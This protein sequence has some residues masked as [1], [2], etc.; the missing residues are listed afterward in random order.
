MI[1]VTVTPSVEE[2]AS[3]Y[4][5]L[6]DFAFDATMG[7]GDILNIEVASDEWQELYTKILDEYDTASK[8]ML[9]YLHFG[10]LSVKLQIESGYLKLVVPTYSETPTH[11]EICD[12]VM[13][14]AKP[15]ASCLLH[16]NSVGQR[17][18][19]P[20][21]IILSEENGLDRLAVDLTIVSYEKE[22]I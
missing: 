14:A 13:A 2:A 18:I 19:I 1:Y 17:M 6:K 12:A 10:V 11:Q 8:F 16:L 4:E 21:A 15:I 9:Y 5:G 3:G 20:D 22:E 7:I